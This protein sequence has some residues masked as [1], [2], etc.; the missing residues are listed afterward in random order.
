M[1]ST[2]SLIPHKKISLI[3]N[4]VHFG[5]TLKWQHISRKIIERRNINQ[6]PVE[7][8]EFLDS[9]ANINPIFMI[10]IDETKQDRYSRELKFGYAPEGEVCIKDQII[11]NKTAYS[12]ITAVVTPMG[13][14]LAD[15]RR[16]H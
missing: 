2:I 4:S 11:I 13:L 15:T 7:G 10:D 1:S 3:P 14:C 12:T 6:N 9:I 16:K 8:L 5:R